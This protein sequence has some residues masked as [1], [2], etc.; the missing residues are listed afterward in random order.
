MKTFAIIALVLNAL[1][2]FA[3]KKPTARQ[4]QEFDAYVEAVR[5]EWD[6]PGLAITVVRDNQ[7]L[8]KKGYGVRELGKSEPVDTQ[9]LFA[10]ASTTKAMTVTLMG[11]LV[12]EGKVSWDDPVYKY[13]PE[14]QFSDPYLTRE[15]KVR[16]LLTHNTGIGSTDFFTG[17]MTIPAQ[18]MFRRMVYVK[19]SYSLRSG[20]IYQNIMYSA[21]GR[22]IERLTGKTW[23]E[24]MQERIFNPLGM[25]QTAPKRGLSKSTN[26]TKPHF[27]VN[28][29]IRVIDYGADSEIGSAGAVWS[30][31]D[32]MSKWVICMLD[33]SKYSGGRLVKPATWSEIFKPQA[34]VPD[35]EYPTMQILKPNWLTYGLGWYQ[36]DYRGHKVNFHTGSLGGLTAITGQ[37][38]DEKLGV[39]VFGNYD[40]AEVRHVLLYKTL[41]F[42]A[43][44]GNRDWNTEFKKLYAGIR[45]AGKKSAREFQEKRILNTAPSLPL[46]AYAGKYTS[47]LYGKAEVTVVGNQLVFNIND[48]ALKATLAH[49][50][51][52]TFY[53]P[54][55]K[56]WYG[57]ALARF[58]LGNSGQVDA[59]VFGGMDFRKE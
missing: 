38:P 42:F 4:L 5:K 41:D 1:T 6:V 14:L 52:D 25:T 49:W 57:K 28:D 36:H 10:C 30:S 20:F 23:A 27:N 40:H 46:K 26:M 7:V 48:N 50:H 47:P 53:G 44:G 43:L 45:E 19:P 13:L 32:D 29:T 15:V 54:F 16:D 2:S 59:L 35:D 8:F 11:M 18:E 31:V 33:S 22:I 56:A 51:F 24:V 9:T 17:A 55:Q 58:S 37:L 21:A 3:Q 39:Y 12:D 34:M